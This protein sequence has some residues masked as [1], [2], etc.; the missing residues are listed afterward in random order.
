MGSPLRAELKL[1]QVPGGHVH[2]P[3]SIRDSFSENGGPRQGPGSPP[4]LR[5]GGPIRGN[6][7]IG[8]QGTCARVPPRL[9]W[10]TQL[11][12]EGK[13]KP[14]A[15]TGSLCLPALPRGGGHR[16]LLGSPLPG[17]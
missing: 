11:S 1:A 13:G 6:L 2:A 3:V 17:V 14:T 15:G 5:R 7:R 10:G 8:V 12:W 4:F 16:L 9:L